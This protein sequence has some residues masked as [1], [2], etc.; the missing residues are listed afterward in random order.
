MTQSPV[1]RR[2]VRL[3]AASNQKAR[4]VGALG[5]I[6]SADLAYIYQR[7]EGQ[8]IYCDIEIDPMHCSFDHVIPFDRQG[9]NRP[10]NIV[11]CCMTCQR[12]KFTKSPEQL[13]QWQHLYLTC[14]VDGTIFRPRWADW[15]RGFGKYCSRRCSGAIGGAT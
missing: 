14:P 1:E 5:R 2:F 9:L 8:C 6:S 12:A 7:G 3:A 15:I 13:E 10:D 11:A 4:R